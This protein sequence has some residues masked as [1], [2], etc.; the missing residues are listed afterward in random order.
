MA[1]RDSKLC[2]QYGWVRNDDV[3]QCTWEFFSRSDKS[4][5]NVKCGPWINRGQW[6]SGT[7]RRQTS[8]YFFQR[9]FRAMG[10]FLSF[11][12]HKCQRTFWCT[13]HII[14]S[15]T[16]SLPSILTASDICTI[17]TLLSFLPMYLWK[18]MTVVYHDGCRLNDRSALWSMT[19]LSTDTTDFTDIGRFRTEYSDWTINGALFGLS[20]VRHQRLLNVFICFSTACVMCR[21]C[22]RPVCLSTIWACMIPAGIWC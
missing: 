21:V 5:D 8:R 22:G 19:H 4:V 12:S 11:K 18:T 16:S 7:H 2:W 15:F 6:T 20:C 1:E 13:Y 17:L 10:Q 9:R 14:F 3:V